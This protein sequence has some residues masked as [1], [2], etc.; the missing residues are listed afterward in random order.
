VSG[1]AQ[2][3]VIWAAIAAMVAAAILLA[4]AAADGASGLLRI[5]NKGFL[6]TDMRGPFQHLDL[7]VSDGLSVALMGLML[8]GYLAI[9]ACAS[10]VPARV[11]I[12]AI[13]ALHLVFLLAPPI[14]SADIFGYIGFARLEVL[15]DLNP[16]R[17]SPNYAPQDAIY[18]FV[19]LEA[20]TTP[21][22]PLFTVVSL[23]V[24]WLSP[25][26]AVWA[27][28]SVFALASL[29]LVALTA[30]C[31]RVRGGDPL[32]AALFVGLNPVLLVFIV[33]GGH[34]DVLVMALA[35]GAV[36]L[37]IRGREALG[38][39]GIVAAA[40][41]KL[42]AALLLPFAVLGAKERLR[43][44][45]WA[46]GA[47]AVAL[48]VSLAIFG[49]TLVSVREEYNLQSKLGSPNDVPGA[50]SDLLG[51][52]IETETLSKIGFLAFAIALVYL[53]WRV[54]RGEDWLQSAG[55]GFVALL[56]STTWFL[57]WYMIWLLPLAAISRGSRQRLAALALTVL[58]IGLQAENVVDPPEAQRENQKRAEAQASPEATSLRASPPLRAGS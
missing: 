11:G 40:A 20:H 15:H 43:A 14:F 46:V 48:G 37:L 44:L 7:D 28:K 24:A 41:A 33:G 6:P 50:I 34:N 52:G 55:W 5:H 51:L 3:V 58:V 22:G 13:V 45:L 39:S 16:Y 30:A 56:V 38:V 17:Y 25:A 21:Y 36:Y 8:A 23:P 27:L 19:G 9:L 54:Y 4:T 53:L 29:G 2:R 32:L 49:T 35:M 42:T 18:P 10:A 26:A 31:A 12:G 57:P 1:N 47:A